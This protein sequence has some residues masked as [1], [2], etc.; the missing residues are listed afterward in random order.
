M[1]VVAG[2]LG[3]RHLA[4][5]PGR[6]TR[7]TSDLVRGAIFN[8]LEAQGLIEG[9]AVVDLFA[10][11][12]AMGIEA[13][14]RGAAQAVFVESNARAARVIE[15]NVAALQ[16][17]D[18]VHIVRMPVE[19]WLAGQLPP[20]DVVLADPPYDWRGW[21]GLLSAVATFPEVVVVAESDRQVGAEGWDTAGV[22]R[23]GGTV[24][25]QLRPR[26]ASSS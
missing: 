17:S 20:V 2:S 3:G 7:P 6:G 15:E 10:G 5:P 22:K 26:G 13:L 8:S 4:V 24:V 16:L 21:E 1:R 12:G 19:R 23:H 18:R 25:T 11:S 9:A 14:S